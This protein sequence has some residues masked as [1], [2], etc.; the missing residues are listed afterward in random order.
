GRSGREDADRFDV[1]VL[2]QIGP[3]QAPAV[4]LR[5][6]AYRHGETRAEGLADPRAQTGDAAV[7]VESELAGRL[8][9]P[10]M[11]GREQIFRARRYPLHGPAEATREPRDQHFLAIRS[12]LH[13]EPA[14]DVGC[15]HTHPRLVEPEHARQRGADPERRLRRGPHDELAGVGIPAR[16]RAARLHRY[17]AQT[18]LLDGQGHPVRGVAEGSVRVAMTP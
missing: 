18:L 2:D 4:V 12:A 7:R 8:A 13:A 15:D 1:D 6:P 3:G 17:A 11:I 16:E 10:A 9:A 5:R 14:A